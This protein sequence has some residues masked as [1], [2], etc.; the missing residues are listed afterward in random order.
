MKE[1]EKAEVNKIYV[2]YMKNSNIK[3]TLTSKNFQAQIINV[4]RHRV[5]SRGASRR[6]DQRRAPRLKIAAL[7]A[8]K[9]K[10]TLM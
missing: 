5:A 4:Y 7:A 8:R 1:K 2:I 3:E 9:T 10:K 6:I